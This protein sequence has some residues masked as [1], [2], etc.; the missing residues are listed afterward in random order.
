MIK[1]NLDIAKNS[2]D[3]AL[4]RSE[5]YLEKISVTAEKEK[6]FRVNPNAVSSVSISPKLIE[7]LPN[8]GEV[9]I[10]RAFQLLPG[11]SGSNETSAGLYVRGGTPDQNLILFD[12]MSIYHVDHFYGFF[13][14]F[15][16]NSIDDVELYKG[17]FPAEFGGRTSSVL[18][19]KGK[20]AD[21][22]NFNLGGS[23]SLLSVNAF[24]EIPI[25]KDKLS[26]QISFRRS[27]TDVIKS[28]LYNNI[29]DMYNDSEDETSLGGGPGGRGGRQMETFEPSFYF[30]DL[31]SKL[32]FKPTKKDLFTFSFYNGKDN[33]DNS[34]SQ[35]F[36]T[37]SE[38]STE[39]KDIVEW[40]NIG[41]ST[42]WQRN[43]T[44]KFMSDLSV[45]YSNYFSIA[46]K[47]IE[48]TTGGTSNL[49][50]TNT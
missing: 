14:A 33:L 19:I 15:N 39:I 41:T 24:T 7:K 30:Y 32:S 44:D 42:G 1:L 18:D 21:M 22:Q 28:G 34:R 48:M 40:G 29:F 50:N 35:T 17:G 5:I 43:W 23:L 6:I 25:V 16:A 8:F 12:G 13:S 47:K 11:I 26:L 37:N 36:G 10:M 46:D 3:I 4:L 9:D 38:N 27:Y 45:S 31:N 49:R 2:L 20:P